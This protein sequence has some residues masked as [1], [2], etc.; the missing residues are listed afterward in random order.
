MSSTEPWHQHMGHTGL[1]KLQATAKCTKGVPNTGNFHP[2]FKCRACATAEMTKTPKQKKEHQAQLPGEQFHMDFGFVRGPKNLQTLLSKRCTAK[3]KMRHAK[4]HYLVKT[5]HDGY[6]SYLL[7]TDAASR[8]TWIFLAKTK[9]P[10]IVTLEVFLTQH[11][12]KN[13]I[14]KFIRTDQGGEL[15][16]STAF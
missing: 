8:H 10:P 1:K 2:P 12:L 3:H 14:P 16:Q 7:V 11:S 9:E 5:S 15:A 6:S 4:S 13:E